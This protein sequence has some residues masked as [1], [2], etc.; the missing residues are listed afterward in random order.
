MIDFKRYRALTFDCYG[1]LIDWDRGLGTWLETW[2]RSKG[3]PL[4]A[5]VWVR[6]FAA[7]ET[8]VQQEHPKAPYPEILARVGEELALEAGLPWSESDALAFGTSVGD[9]PPFPDTADALRALAERFRLVIVSNVDRGSFDR[10]SRHL[11]MI[12]D[13][14]VTAEEVG[15]YKPDPRMFH[16][17]FEV[18]A[19]WGITRGE[20][21]HVAQSLYHDVA[22]ARSLGLDT[23]WVNRTKASGELGASHGGKVSVE[24]DLEVTSLQELADRV[25]IAPRS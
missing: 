15:A 18:L 12:F 24:P 2:A 10:T 22:P 9:W 16:R 25:A 11:G 21:L 13:A 3:S 14:V 6:R 19:E 20:T 4:G 5:S 8:R 1:T 17:A 7:L 23:V